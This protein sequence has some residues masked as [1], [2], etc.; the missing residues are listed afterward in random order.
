MGDRVQ[1]GSMEA[2]LA[3]L[4]IGEQAVRSVS[5]SGV[6]VSEKGMTEP[7]KTMNCW[8]SLCPASPL[9]LIQVETLEEFVRIPLMLAKGCLGGSTSQHMLVND[10]G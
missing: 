6:R 4:N 1:N 5:R 7:P 3:L 2:Q 10:S 9:L 8:P